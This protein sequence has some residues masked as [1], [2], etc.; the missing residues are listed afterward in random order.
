MVNDYMLDRVLDNTKKIT[1]IDKFDDTT[2]FKI[3]K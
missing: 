3:V 1:C 2:N